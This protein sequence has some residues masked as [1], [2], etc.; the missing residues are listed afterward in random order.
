[1]KTI[2]ITGHDTGIGKTWVIKYIARKLSEKKQHVQVVKAV[3]TG[4]KKESAEEGDVAKILKNLDLQYLSG[5]TLNSFEAP[6]APLHAAALEGIKL[7][8]EC[9]HHQITSL[10]ETDWRLIELAGGMAVPL[11]TEGQDGRDLAMK[12]KVDYI[13]LVIQNRLG[14]IN[15]SRLIEAY[16]PEAFEKVGFWLND[17]AGRDPLITHSNLKALNTLKRPLWAHLGFEQLEPDFCSAPFF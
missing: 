13:V 4:I 12:L 6:L 1:M 16:I 14:A 17:T 2:F 9:L 11:D 3:E 15:Q 10:P 7:S 8:I 5:F